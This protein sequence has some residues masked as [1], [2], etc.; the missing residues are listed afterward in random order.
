MRAGPHDERRQYGEQHTNVRPG[1][2]DSRT[3]SVTD[4]TAFI[5]GDPQVPVRS[6]PRGVSREAALHGIGRDAPSTTSSSFVPGAAGLPSPTDQPK[7]P[8]AT[9]VALPW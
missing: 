1:V 9:V 7:E 6:R 2:S 8:A 5:A 3:G 4:P